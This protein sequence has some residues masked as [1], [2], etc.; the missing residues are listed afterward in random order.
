LIS[1]SQEISTR[2]SINCKIHIVIAYTSQ[3]VKSI[4]ESLTYIE[5]KYENQQP[6]QLTYI[7]G[8]SKTA[9]IEQKLVYGAHGPKEIYCFL[10]EG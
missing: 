4:S 5:R 3:I 8:P 1:S 7:S 6:R 10:I 9:D 2:L